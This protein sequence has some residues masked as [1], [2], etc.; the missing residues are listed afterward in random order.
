MSVETDNLWYVEAIDFQKKGGRM[1][2]QADLTF[3]QFEYTT[4]AALLEV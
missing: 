2:T 4:L 1:V 3:Q